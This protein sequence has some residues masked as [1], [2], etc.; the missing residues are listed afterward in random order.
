MVDRAQIPPVAAYRL[1]E[2]HCL[3]S[4][5]LK[6]G[7]SERLTSKTIANYLQIT[8]E[9]V[10]KD[11]SFIEDDIGTP[12]I[13]YDPVKLYKAISKLL[14]VDRA[15]DVSL[16]GSVTTWRGI[17]NFFDPRKFGFMPRFIFS[18]VPSESGLYFDQT[19]VFSIE[20]IPEVLANTGIKTA[21]LACDLMWI[22]RA[23]QLLDQANVK[24]IL[25]LTPTVLDE[26]PTGMYV[27]QV[28]LP[29]EIK[30][31]VYHVEE[32]ILDRKSGKLK[33]DIGKRAKLK[34]TR[35]PKAR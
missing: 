22:R 20:E 12:G 16:I 5:I 26:V 25:N 34:R 9:I 4:E 35:E 2:Y 28:L 29:C 27:S 13:G 3:L 30:L 17:T 33:K 19:P 32:G 31:V 10:R 6:S 23:V 14:H 8:E 21:I 7:M 15:H 18:D 24:G 11:L 1:A